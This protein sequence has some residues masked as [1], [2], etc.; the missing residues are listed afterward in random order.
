MKS[1]T[2]FL[3]ALLYF[4]VA[5][6]AEAGSEA[7]FRSLAV[8]GWGQFYNGQPIKGLVFWGCEAISIASWLYFKD[9][10]DSRYEKYRTTTDP[11]VAASRYTSA[12]DART[13]EKYLAFAALGVWSLNMVD[14]W[15]FSNINRNIL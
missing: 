11:R 4:G 1:A 15:L 7:A 5:D 2:L 12:K 13:V 8:P 9:L 3:L 10:G 6:T 14:A